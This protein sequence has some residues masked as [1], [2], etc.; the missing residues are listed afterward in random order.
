MHQARNS[1]E[2]QHVGKA[3]SIGFCSTSRYSRYMVYGIIESSDIDKTN[4]HNLILF[5]LRHLL[6]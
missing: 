4:K 1:K 5:S 6:K 3:I 2:M